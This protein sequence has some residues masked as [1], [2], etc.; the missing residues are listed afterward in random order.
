MKPASLIYF[1]LL[2]MLFSC[3]VESFQPTND[4][5]PPM[6]MTAQNDGTNHILLQ[7]RGFNYETY[8]SGYEIYVARDAVSANLYD[9]YL[10]PNTTSTNNPT[11]VSSILSA[12]TV[13]TYVVLT[14]MSNA[15][16]TNGNTYYF[17]AKARSVVLDTRS[18]PCSYA[19][20]VYATN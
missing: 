7:F 12:E 9:G 16:L 5:F 6:G 17:W 10:I 1:L 8:F 11:I 14:E 19:S 4:L 15:S 20:V 2:F 18:K 13:F 3:G